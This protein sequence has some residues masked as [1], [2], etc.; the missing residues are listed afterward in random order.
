M[1]C[2]LENWLGLGSN[3]RLHLELSKNGPGW[4]TF[5]I[6][7]GK[8]GQVPWESDPSKQWVVWDV[9]DSKGEYYGSI[10]MN[11]SD[12]NHVDLE[13]YDKGKSHWLE[14]VTLPA[15]GKNYQLK[16]AGIM[17]PFVEFPPIIPNLGW[18]SGMGN[19]DP[20]PTD[21]DCFWVQDYGTDERGRWKV[22]PN[23]GLFQS[24][25]NINGTCGSRAY[26]VR[27]KKDGS[28]WKP[29]EGVGAGFEGLWLIGIQIG[30]NGIKK[31]NLF[32]ESFYLA[33]RNSFEWGGE[34]YGDGSTKKDNPKLPGAAYFSREIDI[35]ETKWHD[36]GVNL[37]LPTG[38]G[39]SWNENPQW[40]IINRVSPGQ[41]PMWSDVGGA[42]TKDLIMFGCLIW[43]SKL[44]LFAYT[45]DHIKI[46]KL[47]QWYC[48]KPI[49][50]DNST[51]VQN[52]PFVP[53]IGTWCDKDNTKPGGFKTL[54]QEFRYLSGDYLSKVPKIARDGMNPY[55]NP[56]EFIGFFL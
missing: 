9:K 26:P 32:C 30:S 12:G 13:K 1:V 2:I 48:T 33:E 21:G 22:D 18:A 31:D 11:N 54:Y 36:G 15:A 8:S 23:A 14:G 40:G 44:W 34:H 7:Y 39:T 51:Y 19:E 4:E 55:D 27:L 3:P 17:P 24:T 42:P 6:D 28:N 20:T 41:W 10:V 49:P 56:D 37:N 5:I 25:D 35:M 38:G 53:Y 29:S 52:H 46:D 43:K 47:N 16:C 50:K 45:S